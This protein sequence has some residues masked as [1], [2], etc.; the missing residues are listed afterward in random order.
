MLNQLWE[1]VSALSK[2]SA[3]ALQVKLCLYSDDEGED[4]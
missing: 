2:S 4:A 3:I 1:L